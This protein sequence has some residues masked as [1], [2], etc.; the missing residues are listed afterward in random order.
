MAKFKVNSIIIECVLLGILSMMCLSC[1]EDNK[2]ISGAYYCH[3]EGTSLCSIIN[4]EKTND[5]PPTVLCYKTDDNYITVKQSPK[6]PQEY[7]YETISYPKCDS[8]NVFF[9]IIDISQD[10]IIGPLCHSDFLK[11]C[12]R[13]NIDSKLIIK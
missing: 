10:S 7:V 6:F 5:I 11:E 2:R 4:F 12:K 8:I 3:M 1:D 9:W 13:L